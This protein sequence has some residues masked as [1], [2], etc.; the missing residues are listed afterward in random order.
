MF[1]VQDKIFVHGLKIIFPLQKLISSHV[2][3]FCPGQKIFCPGQNYFVLDKSDFV[4]DKK[5][6]VWADGQGITFI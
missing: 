1:I 3:N 6:F 4:L 5:H 2:Q